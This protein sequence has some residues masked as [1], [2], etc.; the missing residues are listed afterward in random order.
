MTQDPEDII[1]SEMSGTERQIL[2]DIIHM[3]NL[4]NTGLT[5]LKVK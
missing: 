4:K 1:L 2:H 5:E 3:W